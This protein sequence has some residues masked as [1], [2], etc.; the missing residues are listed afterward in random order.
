[1]NFELKTNAFLRYLIA[2]AT[3]ARIYLAERSIELFFWLVCI[4]CGIASAVALLNG[5]YW[6][7]ALCLIIALCTWPC[8]CKIEVE[9]KSKP[10]KD[11]PSDDSKR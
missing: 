4:A 11:L 8:D 9:S 5:W 2:K 7:A 10:D 1:M 3:P 6:L